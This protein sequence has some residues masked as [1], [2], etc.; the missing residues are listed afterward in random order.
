VSNKP[1][2]KNVI[3][4]AEYKQRRADEASICIELGEGEPPIVV[5]P[6]DLWPDDL[7][8]RRGAKAAAIALL[9]QDEYDRFV[10]AGGS[11]NLLDKI[12]G[13]VTAEKQGAKPGKSSASDDS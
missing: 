4:L 6:P 2:Y 3:N 13:D 7:P 1:N 12:I 11:G 9:G 8:T 5:P 10:K